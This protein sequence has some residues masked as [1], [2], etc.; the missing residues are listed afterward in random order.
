MAPPLYA[1]RRVVVT[2]L[3]AVTPLGTG[4][5][6][7]WSRLLDSRSG[8]VS[9]KDVTHVETGRTYEGIPSLVAALVPKRELAAPE[10]V[11]PALDGAF[12]VG[13][14]VAKGEDRKMSPFMHYAMAASHQAIKDAGWNPSTDLERERTGVC[15]GSGIGCMD[16]IEK[17]TMQYSQS[18][19]RRISPYVVPKLLINLAAGHVSM[20]YGF[21]GPNH[22]V[23]TACTTGAHAIGDAMRFIQFGDADVMV[24]GGSEASVSPLAMA[25]FAK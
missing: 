2:G 7:T 16:E 17:M 18:G 22:S 4:V 1:A 20:K 14:W 24:A 13:D 9:L 25:G 21:Q 10:G 11:D 5:A 3:G 8:L 6:R 12:F 23:S 15:I 19:M